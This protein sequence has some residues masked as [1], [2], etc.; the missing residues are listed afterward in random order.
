MGWNCGS[1]NRDTGSRSTALKLN[2]VDAEF[3]A[4][5]TLVLGK[6][7]FDR[8]C[9]TTLIICNSGTCSSTLLC[10]LASRSIR[11]TIVKFD[12]RFLVDGDIELSD[13]EGL[14]TADFIAEVIIAQI[15]FNAFSL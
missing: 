12:I 5:G 10:L 7:H 4:L 11:H 2:L 1:R 13:G 14:V 6:L 15:R 8:L 9:S 3:T